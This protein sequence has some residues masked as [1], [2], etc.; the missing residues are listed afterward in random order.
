MSL[1]DFKLFTKA[2][3]AAIFG[4]CTKTIDNYIREGRLPPPVPFA[5][6]EYWHPEDFRAFLDVTFRR[7]K[8][9]PAEQASGLEEVPSASNGEAPTDGKRRA[10]GRGERDSN[11]AV[12]QQS[13][14]QARL[15]ALNAGT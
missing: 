14:Q 5:S 6:R 11:P 3:A 9:A 2:D 15:R 4:V 10:N 8:P 12:R 1:S 7:G 13:R